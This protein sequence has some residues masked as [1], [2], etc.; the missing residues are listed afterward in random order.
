MK[1]LVLLFVFLSSLNGM[2]Q[3]N[4]NEDFE[5]G[6]LPTG[7]SIQNGSVSSVG[8]I[9][10]TGALVFNVANQ[11]TGNLSTTNFVSNG[12]AITILFSTRELNAG[13]I[14]NG[15]R[16]FIN[17]S[18]FV[19]LPVQ[20]A[21]SGSI[22]PF[23]NSFTIPA[24]SVPAG[25]NVSFSFSANVASGNITN[26]YFDNLIISQAASSTIVA[27]TISAVSS[28]N[29]TPS[30]ASI[31]YSVN[32]GG[33][34]TTS[35]IRYGVTSG[36]L[37]SSS[38]GFNSGGNS[39]ISGTAKLTGLLPNTLYYYQ[40][41]A[42]NSVQTTFFPTIQSFT[43]P[44]GTAAPVAEFLFDNSRLSVSG[45]SLFSTG[46]ST[47][48]A[49]RLGIA[50]KAIRLA[51]SGILAVVDGLPTAAASRSI[52]VWIRPTT[53]AADNLIFTYGAANG[54]SAYGGSFS[55]TSIFQFTYSSNL[56]VTNALPVNT[57]KHLV[58]TYE[59]SSSTAKVY[60]DGVLV[61]SGS[62]PAWNTAVNST[63]YLGSL[64][65]GNTGNFTGDIDDLK[66]YNTA[67]TDAQILNLFN[68]ND[69]VTL[70]VPTFTQ[71]AAVCSGCPLMALPL[72]STN[73]ITGTW[74]P[75]INNNTTTTYTFTP[76][77]GQNAATTTM[78][79]VIGTLKRW[80][81][82]NPT[83]VPSVPT[84]IDAVQIENNYGPPAATNLNVHSMTVINNAVVV[85][86]SGSNLT[87]AG[88][89]VVQAGSSF[90]L[91][92]DANLIQTSNASNSGD[93]T[94]KRNSSNLYRQ[95]YTLWSS[96]VVGQNLRN[97]SPQTLFNRF[98]SYSEPTGV[99]VQ[100]LVTTADVTS[101]N[102]AIGKGYLIRMPNN[103]AEY[104]SSAT[105]GIS[106]IGTFTGVPANGDITVPLSITNQKYNLVGNPYPSSISIS[107]FLA[108]NSNLVQNLYFWR[109]RNGAIGSGFATWSTLGVVS[110]QAETNNAVV[111]NTIKSGQGFFI[112][113]NTASNVFFNN[114]MRTS[115]IAA[116]TFF[117]GSTAS[118]KATNSSRIWINLKKDQEQVGQTL[119]GYSVDANNGIDEMDAIYFNDSELALTSLI[120]GEEYAIQG[121][122]NFATADVIPLGFKT[123]LA[124]TYVISLSNFDGIFETNQAIY[125]KDNA[126][127]LE[128]NLKTND[129]PF[130]SPTG[131]FNSRFELRF[132][133]TLSTNGNAVLDNTVYVISDNRNIAVRSLGNA[134]E[135]IDIFDLS[136]RLVFTK[137]EINNTNFEI[138]KLTLANQVLLVKVTTND[139]KTQ[140]K[141]IIF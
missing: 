50:N 127:G 38:V 24:G 134:I 70:T 37:L 115:I 43:T 112:R 17:S 31:N 120:N 1:K 6:S 7:W 81:G 39:S 28:S 88:N 133:S 11:A 109:K 18:T 16:Y 3:I 130:I 90:N 44:A 128:T 121:R 101:K 35:T 98:Y 53:I 64:F 106:F 13:F 111:S 87:L 108:N 54:N 78:T 9:T 82:F 74:S 84:A 36:S 132:E 66:I 136:G 138:N 117:K 89:L 86:Q 32:A 21:R 33:E 125:L 14:R 8:A 15:G 69:I 97:F 4:L 105:P 61:N 131:V 122:N 124:G 126:T 59:N 104:V 45:L 62:F 55:P 139:K 107:S 42:S 123:D 76:S 56:A 49:N 19:D 77:A 23:V 94:V 135:K 141:K 65:G 10:G 91:L 12:N 27:P 103:W 85:F 34:A 93:I 92:N 30:T 71:V 80:T 60:L 73:N 41:E 119:V 58:F 140:I 83:W 22:T 26:Q 102:F 118:N 79:I 40:V 63:F 47:F 129:Y 57:W 72:T 52:S 25:A 46:T 113:S 5:S 100:E 95:D 96:P 20:T 75:I 2:T 51:S 114:S 29:I 137:S 116:T 110:A 68:I 48:V 99:Y 67:L